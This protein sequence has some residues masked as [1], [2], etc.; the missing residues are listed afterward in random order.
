MAFNVLFSSVTKIIFIILSIALKERSFVTSCPIDESMES[1]GK[2]EVSES[3]I[4]SSLWVYQSANM[5]WIRPKPRGVVTILLLMAGDIETCPGPTPRR[6]SLECNKM[7]KI[8]Q[9]SSTGVGCNQALQ[10][11]IEDP[12]TKSNCLKCCSCLQLRNQVNEQ[13]TES[14]G[15]LMADACFQ[16]FH[17]YVIARGL[18]IFHQNVCGLL[19]VLDQVKILLHEVKEIDIF[20][21]GESH[22]DA[23]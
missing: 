1:D 2:F 17:S 13:N 10:S 6:I 15:G 9:Q 22:L 7:I 19:R 21:V 18:I 14:K 3:F 4:W 5:V 8:N 11:D 20:G 23:K 12:K 16:K